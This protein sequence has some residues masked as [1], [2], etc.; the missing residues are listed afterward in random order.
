MP[1]SSGGIE[2]VMGVSVPDSRVRGRQD[3]ERMCEEGPGEWPDEY[4]QIGQKYW[5]VGVC[6]S[7]LLPIPVSRDASAVS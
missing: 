4:R 7:R 5:R 6:A 1:R 2:K 3:L